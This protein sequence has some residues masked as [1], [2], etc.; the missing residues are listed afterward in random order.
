[1]TDLNEIKTLQKMTREMH[2]AFKKERGEQF[3][4]DQTKVYIPQGAFFKSAV[5]ESMKL[6]PVTRS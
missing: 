2:E 4:K 6:M 1:M 5:E 3:L